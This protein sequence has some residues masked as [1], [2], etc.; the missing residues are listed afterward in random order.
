M[1]DTAV[2]AACHLP[3][4]V[5]YLCGS[6][7]N[8]RV[9]HKIEQQRKLTGAQVY[10]LIPDLYYTAGRVNK[11]VA[12]LEWRYLQTAGAVIMVVFRIAAQ[13]GPS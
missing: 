5:A 12:H 4:V 11:D 6:Q 8:I 13:L 10:Q 3:G 2:V 1:R 7:Y 9:S